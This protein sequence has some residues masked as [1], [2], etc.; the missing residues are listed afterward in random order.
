[1]DLSKLSYEQ[2]RYI[3]TLH[4][5]CGVFAMYDDAPRRGIL[6]GF[7]GEYQAEIQFYEEDGVNVFEHPEYVEM[8]KVE[9]NLS[10]LA[11]INDDEAATIATIAGYIEVSF[12]R[13]RM[14]AIGRDI[15]KD[16]MEDSN[17]TIEPRRV[18]F[19]LQQL[20]QWNFDIPLYF[21]VGHP[22]NGFTARKIFS[23]I[24]FS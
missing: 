1:M 23:H 17:I 8:H 22:Y 24:K 2:L 21:G 5:G 10:S 4:T 14:I 12:G 7:H 11:L 15:I 20:L 13:D 6:T 16:I 18:F 19:I 9:L 3:F